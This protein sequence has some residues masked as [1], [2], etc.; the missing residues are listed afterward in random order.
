MTSEEQAVCCC[1]CFYKVLLCACENDRCCCGGELPP[2]NPCDLYIG[3]AP[4]DQF[5]DDNPGFDDHL[6]FGLFDACAPDAECCYVVTRDANQVNAVPPEGI[7]IDIPPPATWYLPPFDDCLFCCPSPC[8]QACCLEPGIN[9][10]CCFRP[11]MDE[12]TVSISRAAFTITENCNVGGTVTTCAALAAMRTYEMA[13]C[14]LWLPVFGDSCTYSFVGLTCL[15]PGWFTSEDHTCTN[16]CDTQGLCGDVEPCIGFCALDD[17][18]VA[19]DLP[20]LCDGFGFDVTSEILDTYT[21]GGMPPCTCQDIVLRV[22]I[23]APAQSCFNFPALC[24][25]QPCTCTS[26]QL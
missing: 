15:P 21:F 14:H 3:C 6:V 12:L 19:V 7:L 10:A 4:M 16:L 9:P 2:T 13:G 5:F 18:S 23:S 26:E 25:N 22:R 17:V 24:C 8:C 1:G 20:D 11:D